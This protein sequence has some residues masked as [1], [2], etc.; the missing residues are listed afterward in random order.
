MKNELLT[1]ITSLLHQMEE[2]LGK[3]SDEQYTDPLPVLSGAT[4]GQHTRHILEF[5]IELNVGYDTG[6]I[7]YDNRKRD[8]AIEISR[9]TAMVQ[10]AS[11]LSQFEKDDKTLVLAADYG[12]SEACTIKVRTNYLRELVYNMEH[13]VHHMALLRIGIQTYSGIELPENFGV[14]SSTLK[15]RKSCAQ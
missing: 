4:I 6:L 10:I 9:T 11:L 3:L 13:M 8:C 7:N 2:L 12:T 1:P 14:A 5:F 15:Y